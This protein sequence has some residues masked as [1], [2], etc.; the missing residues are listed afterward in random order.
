MF[1]QA[2]GQYQQGRILLQG[3]LSLEVCRRT[4]QCADGQFSFIAQ[5]VRYSHRKLERAQLS[6]LRCDSNQKIQK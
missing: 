4:H 2:K 6:G 5:Q 1:Q 3:T